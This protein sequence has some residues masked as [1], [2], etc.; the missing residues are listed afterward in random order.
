MTFSPRIVNIIIDWAHNTTMASERKIE[1]RTR[2]CV[3]A[4]LKALHC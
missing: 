2:F 4:A 3:E 1:F